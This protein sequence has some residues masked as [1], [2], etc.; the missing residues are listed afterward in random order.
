MHPW[1]ALWF[2]FEAV[3]WKPNA[4]Q[5]SSGGVNVLTGEASGLPLSAQPQNYLVV[6]EQPWLDGFKTS[7]GVVSQFVA[8]PFGEGKP[9]KSRSEKG[10]ILADWR[11]G[12]SSQSWSVFEPG[13][14][15]VYLL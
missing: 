1:E 5:L 13:A 2:S 9:S 4:V 3:S 10:S 11:S 7:A 14:S 15:R 8:A 6:P 12:S